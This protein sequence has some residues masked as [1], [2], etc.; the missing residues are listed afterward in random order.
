MD[1]G[2]VP[3]LSR[4]SFQQSSERQHQGN[5]EALKAVVGFKVTLI[6]LPVTKGSGS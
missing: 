4:Q 2:T 3:L 6:P 1:L 5:N